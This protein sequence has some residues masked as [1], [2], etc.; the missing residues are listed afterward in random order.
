M[1]SVVT[2]LLI[3]AFVLS[4]FAC[5]GAAYT[6]ESSVPLYTLTNLRTGPRGTVSSVAYVDLPLLPVCT[7]VE[8]DAVRGRQI[9][10]RANGR[11]YRY[12]AHRSSPSPTEQHVQR[13]FGPS[14]PDL[15]QASPEDRA[16]IQQGQVFQGMT[17]AGVILAM[18]YPPERFT[19]TLDADVWT[20]VR[21]RGGRL[22][23]QFAG[24][25]VVGLLDP[26]ARGMA[27]VQ[28]SPGQPVVQPAGYGG[29]VGVTVV[30][31]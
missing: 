19:P 10:F 6:I 3:L 1:L 25:R 13:L 27:T 26:R 2:R 21:R 4:S 17:K 28:P 29:Q 9:V 5:G 20:Y 18:G 11:R 16:G 31:P 23:V 15:S 22:S 8:I 7:P 14:C 24:G 30:A 12:L